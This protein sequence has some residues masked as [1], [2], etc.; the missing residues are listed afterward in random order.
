MSRPVIAWGLGMCALVTIGV[1][2]F[3]V[4]GPHTTALLYGIGGFMVVLGLVL[5]ALRLDRSPE[6]VTTATPALSPPATFAAL[7]VVLASLA[8][9]AGPWAAIIGGGM[10]LVGLAGIARELRAQRRTER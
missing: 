2:A 1:L 8:V 3:D 9:V 7:G 10:A 6:T 4:Q 5:V